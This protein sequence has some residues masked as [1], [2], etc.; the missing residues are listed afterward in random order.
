MQTQIHT[1]TNVHTLK[2]HAHTETYTHIR[3]HSID[4]CYDYILGCSNGMIIT[5]CIIL[6][7]IVPVLLCKYPSY[8]VQVLSSL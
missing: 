4:K 7:F 5:V 2:T 6:H 1:C 3:T 8:I